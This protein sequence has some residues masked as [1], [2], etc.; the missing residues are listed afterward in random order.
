MSDDEIIFL[1]KQI[2]AHEKR[3]GALDRACKAAEKTGAELERAETE[4]A[5]RHTELINWYKRRPT[6]KKKQGRPTFWRGPDGR[7]FVCDVEAVRR[8]ERCTIATAVEKVVKRRKA[9]RHPSA[10]RL[11]ALTPRRRRRRRPTQHRPRARR[12]RHTLRE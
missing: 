3:A 11:G 8:K 7:T 6:K 9:M 1:R 4:F 12:N 5:L 10:A 2:E